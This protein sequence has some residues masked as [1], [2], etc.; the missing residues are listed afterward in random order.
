VMPGKE[1]TIAVVDTTLSS[2]P[3]VMATPCLRG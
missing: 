2:G 1:T 3:V